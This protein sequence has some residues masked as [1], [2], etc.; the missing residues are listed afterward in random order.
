MSNNILETYIKYI[1]K[2]NEEPITSLHVYDF[3]ST[4]FNTPKQKIDLAIGIES[5]N[6]WLESIVE[7]ARKSIDTYNVL[8]VMCTARSAIDKV[9]NDTEFLLANKG[10]NFDKIFFKPTNR[11]MS[12]A[13]YKSDYIEM[14]LNDYPHI[15]EIIFYDDDHRNLLSVKK[16]AIARGIRYVAVDPQ[17]DF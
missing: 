9:M 7:Q 1:I 4:L 16:L 5:N 15:Q 10:L 8:T 17:L 11:K 14:V 6:Y 3:D 13:K 12:N 2:K